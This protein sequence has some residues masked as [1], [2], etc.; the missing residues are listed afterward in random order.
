MNAEAEETKFVSV[1]ELQGQTLDIDLTDVEIYSTPEFLAEVTVTI[2][3]MIAE[4]TGAEVF[5]VSGTI[6][7]NP[8]AEFTEQSGTFAQDF[9]AHAP[10]WTDGKDYIIS[11]HG[12]WNV[13][14]H[15]T[16]EEEGEQEDVVTR[17]TI[18]VNVETVTAAS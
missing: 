2:A 16:Y 12:E 10:D 4:E 18:V 5:A 3:S 9:K 8:E 6:A 1:Q 11:T 7:A 17:V 13:V 15:E 14:E